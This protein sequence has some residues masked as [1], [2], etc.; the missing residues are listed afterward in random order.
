MISQAFPK[1]RS[2]IYHHPKSLPVPFCLL[3]LDCRHTH[4]R[5]ECFVRV[6]G[7]G[8]RLDDERESLLGSLQ[9]CFVL[10]SRV[11]WDEAANKARR[12]M[13]VHGFRSLRCIGKRKY[14]MKM[15]GVGDG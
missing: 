7:M 8:G 12:V 2:Y 9:G 10:W 6:D 11:V 1:V 3:P 5:L 13:S 4:H 15:A 14:R